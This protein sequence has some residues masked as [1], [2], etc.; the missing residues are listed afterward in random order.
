MY[1]RI[2]VPID[3]STTSERA[4]QE[5]IRLAEGKA[6]LRVAYVLEEIFPLDTEG[7]AFIDYAALQ[8]AVRHTGERTLAQAAEKARQSGMTAE[9]ALLDAKGKR[10]AGVIKDDALHWQADLIVIGTHGR[11]GL[12]RLLLGSVAEGVARDAPVPVLLIRAE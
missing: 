10:I 8:E 7:Y 3:G 2:L 6:Q 11:S 1:Q 12:S 9:T 5:A 4:L